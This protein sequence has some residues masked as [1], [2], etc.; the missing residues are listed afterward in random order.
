MFDRGKEPIFLQMMYDNK[1]EW[2]DSTF[3]QAYDDILSE[4]HAIINSFGTQTRRDRGTQ[5]DGGVDQTTQTGELGDPKLP[6]SQRTG[7][8]GE[9]LHKPRI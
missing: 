1:K 7:W 9:I 3:Y 5:T 4:Q 2:P 6:L 8:V